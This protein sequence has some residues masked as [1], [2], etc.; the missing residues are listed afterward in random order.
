MR[1]LERAGELRKGKEKKMQLGRLEK[2]DGLALGWKFQTGEK[3][4]ESNGGWGAFPASLLK[5][6]G[7]RRTAT[8]GRGEGGADAAGFPR[9]VGD[10]T[11]GEAIFAFPVACPFPSL[12]V[13]AGGS[14]SASQP[15]PFRLFLAQPLALCVPLHPS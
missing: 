14:S 13:G 9:R 15:F 4:R 12:L 8:H 5:R 10:W 3:K 1:V 6:S 7:W 11:K 2:S